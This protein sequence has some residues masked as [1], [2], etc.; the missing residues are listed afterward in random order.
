MYKHK[1]IAITGGPCAGKTTAMQRIVDE[2]TERGYKVFVVSETATD[3]INGG[4]RPFGTGACDIVEFQRYVLYMQLSKEK[5]FEKVASGCKQDTIILC[6]R[7]I[8]DNR[9]Y[10]NDEY[11][12]KLLKERNL[13][14]MEVMSSYDLVIHLVTAADGA[15]EYYTTVNNKARTET[16]E[17]AMIADKKTLDSWTGHDKLVIVDNKVGFDEKIDN[18]I[19][20]IYQEL[21]D[22]HPI[23][24]QHKFLVDKIDLNG[25]KDMHLVKLEL[26]QFFVDASST[27]NTM[28]RKTTKNGESIY[29]STIKRDTDV[30]DERITISK[31]ITEK[32]YNS[33]MEKIDDVPIRK[34][35]YC[36]TFGKQYYRLDIF[37]NPKNLA[38]LEIDLTNESKKV[39]IPEFITVK[40]DVTDDLEYRNANIFRK[41]NG[42]RKNGILVKKK[43]GED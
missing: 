37:E 43:A 42:R 12:Q 29:T 27:Q 33:L 38:I 7:G 11:F 23:Q 19:K 1:K 17:E 34:C 13:K 3:L 4:I 2:F 9:A 16:P 15:R 30:S 14:E 25:L 32:D 22:P 10:I 40:K 35:R 41:I 5:L 6:D 31:K 18:A 24:K 39:I 21:G 28:A 26:E 36:F 20:S 8:M